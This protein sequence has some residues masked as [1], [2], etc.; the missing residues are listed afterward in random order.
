MVNN[1][2]P[3]FLLVE[4]TTQGVTGGVTPPVLITL[5]DLKSSVLGWKDD[6]QEVVVEVIKSSSYGAC[7]KREEIYGRNE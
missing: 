3:I 5:W 7:P 4:G 6:N 2:Y 1:L